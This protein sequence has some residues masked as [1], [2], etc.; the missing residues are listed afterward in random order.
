MGQL[1]MGRSF[2]GIG[3]LFAGPNAFSAVVSVIYD[4][5]SRGID[6]ATK[7][8]LVW[9]NLNSNDG[10]TPLPSCI[11]DPNDPNGF[12]ASQ[13][14]MEQDTTDSLERIQNKM[15]II[16]GTTVFTGFKV[17]WHFAASSPLPPT[18]C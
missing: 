11:I 9:N 15:G 6:A 13:A 2:D 3:G 7:H 14:Q 12:I 18:S 1:S 16:G 5:D 10:C 8:Y 17:D 4:Q